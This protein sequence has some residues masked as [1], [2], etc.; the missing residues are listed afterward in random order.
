[1]ANPRVRYDD[2]DQ[3]KVCLV[4]VPPHLA[5]FLYR[6]ALK[7]RKGEGGTQVEESEIVFRL[8]EKWI[9]G[10]Q[11]VDWR[12][13]LSELKAEAGEDPKTKKRKGA[14]K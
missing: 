9:E 1:M 6:E 4:K 13:L 7:A 10:Q 11:P 3:P 8:I 14:L 5:K 12:A 2:A